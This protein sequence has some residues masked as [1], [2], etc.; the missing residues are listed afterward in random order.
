MAAEVAEITVQYVNYPREGK[1]RGS[2]KSS[3]GMAFWGRTDMLKQ[4][5]VGE[6][7][8]VEFFTNEQGFHQLQKKIW[9]GDATPAAKVAT[10][11]RS[12]P[13][14]S[15]DILVAVLLKEPRFDEWPVTD[16]VALIKKHRDAARMSSISAQRRD[17]MADEIP[18]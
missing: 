13:A 6:V 5:Q 1:T 14:D 8:K 16:I 15:E 17:D 7:C 10:R 9:N 4:F 11:P 3:E 2:I 18:Y 12:N